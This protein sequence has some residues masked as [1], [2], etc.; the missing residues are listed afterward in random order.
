[1]RKI[2]IVNNKGGV[3][4]TTNAMNIGTGLAKMGKRVLLIDC[5]PQG[6]LTTCL[7][8]TDIKISTWDIFNE[9]AT[10][11]DAIVH[12][13]SGC[14]LL[15]TPSTRI[16]AKMNTILPTVVGYD[17]ILAEAIAPIESNYDYIFVDCQPDMSSAL[18]V[19]ALVACTEIF[20]PIMPDFLPTTGT[21]QLKNEIVPV[22]KRLNKDIKV[23][24]IIFSKFK[25]SN[26][27]RDM[28]EMVKAV[29]GDVTFKT[30]I[31]DFVDIAAAPGY[32]MSIYEYNP[33]SKAAMQYAELCQEIIAQEGTNG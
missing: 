31:G 29:F 11:G 5:E 26:L 32:G 24:G 22:Q 20:I 28:M 16:L 14:D 4:K 27:S 12:T 33:N 21:Q 13:K 25:R 9:A 8:V 30:V 1:M 19:N 6:N 7:G 23:T 17:K 15:P 2:A 3:A 10:V 18:T